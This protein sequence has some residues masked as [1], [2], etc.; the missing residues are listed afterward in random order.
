VGAGIPELDPWFLDVLQPRPLAKAAPEGRFMEAERDMRALAASAAMDRAPAE[1]VSTEFAAEYRIPGEVTVPSDSEPHQFG[2]AEYE[3]KA[4]LAVKTVPKVVPTAFLYSR[5]RYEGTAPLLPG[6]VAVFRGAAF[7]ARG[8]LPLV[9][10]GEDLDLSFG[11]DDKVKIGYALETGKRSQKGIFN[12]NVR[13]ERRYRI[14]VENH[15]GR[16]LEITVLDQLPV[17]QDERIKVQ[18][19]DDA[20]PPT[21][22]DVEGVKG[23]VRWTRVYGAQEKGLIQFGYS[24][25]YPEGLIVP[26]F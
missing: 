1:E 6:P 9:R 24:V 7:I 2:I 14:E 19:P 12:K 23:V 4:D 11:A 10:P 21:E 25:T 5:T 20:T 13:V 18:L 15:H 17:P 22:R 8:S 3:L 26:G 16:P